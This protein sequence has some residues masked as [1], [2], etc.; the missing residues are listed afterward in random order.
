MQWLQML[1]HT[2]TGNMSPR[3]LRAPLNTNHASPKVRAADT[4]TAAG[5]RSLVL[6]APEKRVQQKPM[7]K[8]CSRI[9]TS[10]FS[11]ASKMKLHLQLHLQLQLQLQPTAVHGFFSLLFYV[12]YNSQL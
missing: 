6:S 9:E 8:P 10:I 2:V 7:Q 3:S 1:Q 11:P 12:L 4:M 5:D